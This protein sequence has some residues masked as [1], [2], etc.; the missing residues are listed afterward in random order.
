ML[1]SPLTSISSQLIPIGP[2]LLDPFTVAIFLAFILVTES[3]ILWGF[4]WGSYPISLLHAFLMNLA[5]VIVVFF[6]LLF[7]PDIGF[8]YIFIAVVLSIVIEGLVLSLLRRQEI[9]KAWLVALIAN[10]VSTAII[11]ASV[12]IKDFF[13]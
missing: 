10:L 6:V 2:L 9:R 1:L 4:D 5:S 7:L 12:Y 8:S 3:L 11:I 13:V